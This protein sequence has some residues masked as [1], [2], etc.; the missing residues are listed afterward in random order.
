[1][2]DRI[3]PPRF[4][5]LIGPAQLHC[6]HWKCTVY[7][8]ETIEACYPFPVRVVRPRVEVVYLD[9]DYLHLYQQETAPDERS[10]GE[11]Q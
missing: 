8:T 10:A 2:V 9:K 7:Y 3:D 5:P 1:M 11:E 6:C 4:Y